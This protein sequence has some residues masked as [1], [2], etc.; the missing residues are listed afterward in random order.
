MKP[1]T[2]C[3]Q[4]RRR[5]AIVVAVIF[6]LAL[7]VPSIASAGL[8]WTGKGDQTSWDNKKNWSPEQV[9]EA[10]DEVTIGIRAPGD[11]AGNVQLNGNR[12]VKGLTLYTSGYIDGRKAVGGR[13]V[14]SHR[15][16]ISEHLTWK[17]GE[18]NSHVTLQAGSASRISGMATKNLGQDATLI[19]NGSLTFGSDARVV[20]LWHRSVLTN[21]RTGRLVLEH[22]A[23]LNGE[24]GNI[25]NQGTLRVIRGVLPVLDPNATLQDLTV[26]FDGPGPPRKTGGTVQVERGVLQLVAGIHQIATSARFTGAGVTRMAD[27]A[28]G[29]LQG[30]VDLSGGTFELGRGGHLAGT[31]SFVGG[32]LFSWTGGAIEGA[33]TIPPRKQEPRNRLE[34]S[35]S[36][37]KQL[38]VSAAPAA[39]PAKLVNFGTA[40]F[41]GSG[42]LVMNSSAVLENAGQLTIRGGVLAEA[43]ACCVSPAKILNRGTLISDAGGPLGFATLRGPALENRGTARLRTGRLKIEFPPYTQTAGR[44]LL[45]GGTISSAQPVLLK[46]G[47]LRGS[48]QLDAPLTNESGVVAP[49]AAVAPSAPASTATIRVLG[50]YSQ[51]RGG[52][53]WIE[54]S[55][56]PR[57]IKHDSLEV[58]GTAIV[59]GT[60]RVDPRGPIPAAA[61]RLKIITASSRDPERGFRRFQTGALA[62]ITADGS[63]TFTVDKPEHLTV[64]MVIDLVNKST[65]AVLAPGRKITAINSSTRVVTY[66]GTDMKARPGTH[67]PVTEAV[68]LPGARAY[69]AAYRPTGVDLRVMTSFRG[70][71]KP[72]AGGRLPDTTIAV[73][74]GHVIE[75]TNDAVRLMSRDGRKVAEMPTNTF[76]GAPISNGDLF[77]PK[78]VF[79]RIGPNRRVYL[80]ALEMTSASQTSGIWLAVSRSSDP[81]SLDH[82]RSWCP[83]RID[84]K[85]ST[86]WPTS[87]PSP[88]WA[89]YPGIAVGTTKVVITTNHVS[90]ASPQRVSHAEVRVL[91]KALLADNA[92]R[93]PPLLGTH[94]IPA[95]T[96]MDSDARWLAPV[97]PLT[98]PT[99]SSAA[100]NPVYLLSANT[101]PSSTY[102]VWRVSDAPNGPSLNFA[103][104][105]GSFTFDLPPDSPQ[106]GG[107]TMLDTGDARITQAVSVGNTI[108]AVH[109]TRCDLGAGSAESCIR[110]VQIDVGVPPGSGALTATLR[111]ETNYGQ[112]DLFFTYPGV[113]VN[114]TGLTALIFEASGATQPLSAWWTTKA[115]AETTFQPPNSL[116][117][118]TCNRAE[119]RF[120]DYT[121]TQTDVDKPGFWFAG[122]RATMLAG[123]CQWETQIG[124][125]TP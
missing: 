85:S 107:G 108:W 119:P 77:D 55:R 98:P 14:M 17:G 78:I 106:P 124:G 74:V 122:E 117:I 89:D 64:G 29:W 24:D 100:P 68:A 101:G 97:Q 32:G 82:Q 110:A 37:E 8:T 19:N 112:P 65:G 84:S 76:F 18:I 87:P 3:D 62:A 52:T 38:T 22:G 35:G 7:A 26:M 83:Y 43:T 58:A 79:D 116:S 95:S 111:Q 123:T 70:L 23:L 12:R 46:G 5:F 109:A 90:F 54:V 56:T 113:A 60:L 96:A 104:V 9:P 21:T 45:A 67:V 13:T 10:T 33:I 36:D 120:G 44:T 118:G 11:V 53:L 16:T 25:R 121:G 41:E 50:P 20:N 94:M 15:L 73:T 4:Q 39:A 86:P 30:A 57:G 31:G 40:S 49:G 72:S 103:G 93:C 63:H 28:T 88:G 42:K 34:I 1:S 105:S 59:D 114:R 47:A 99:S 92:R 66:D 71:D 27:G 102:R 51:T 75:A 115:A 61:N 91:R 81:K 6:L 125:V 48:G 69:F 80:I 2:Y